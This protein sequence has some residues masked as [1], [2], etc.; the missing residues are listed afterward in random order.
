VSAKAKA[1]GAIFYKRDELA[2]KTLSLPAFF[3][4]MQ[5]YS[6]KH[7]SEDHSVPRYNFIAGLRKSANI[8]KFFASHARVRENSKFELNVIETEFEVYRTGG[9]GLLSVENSASISLFITRNVSI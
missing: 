8:S 6:L 2:S 9:I 7:G 1:V 5:E 3:S 4:D